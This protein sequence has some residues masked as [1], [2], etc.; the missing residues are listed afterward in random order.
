[1]WTKKETFLYAR[2]CEG[3]VLHVCSGAADLGDIKIDLF[4]KLSDLKADGM[5]LPLK[6]Q[7]VDTAICDPPWLVNV[8]YKILKELRRVARKRILFITTN[9]VTFPKN[10]PWTLTDLFML[11]KKGKGQQYPKIFYVWQKDDN[12]ALDAFLKEKEEFT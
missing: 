4:H 9:V 5:K 6:D 11:S 3:T 10:V 12:E 8:E 1:M 7:C 2:Y